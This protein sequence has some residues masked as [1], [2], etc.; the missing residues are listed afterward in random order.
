MK[1]TVLLTVLLIFASFT[2]H[3]LVIR[4]P[5][6]PARVK[7]WHYMLNFADYYIGMTYEHFDRSKLPKLTLANRRGTKFSDLHI[8]EYNI[9]SESEGHKIPVEILVPKNYDKSKPTIFQIHGGGF[10][11][12]GN[13]IYPGYLTE[14]GNLVVSVF[15]RL[16]PEYPFPAQTNDVFEAFKWL[17]KKDHKLLKD[18][19]VSNIIVVGDS[20]GGN[21]AAGLSYR[22][23]DEKFFEKKIKKQVLVY[24]VIHINV[25]STQSRIDHEHAYILPRH[26]M[27]WF[28][29]QYHE[30]QKILA[31]NPLA[32]ITKAKNHKNLP[33]TFLIVMNYDPLYSEG[34]DYGELLKKN[35]VKVEIKEYPTV[36]GAYGMEFIEEGMK[37]IKDTMKFISK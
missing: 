31:E 37:A 30:D 13:A 1:S 21:L 19:D 11:L 17:Y 4:D 22:V 5:E 8:E 23:R 3:T 25:V 16:A 10:V 15:Y 9:T 36:H 18:V 2:Y 32:S 20:A 29:A 33:E 28:S 12:Q 7:L 14:N 24:P 6:I 35:D 34:K 26:K 27:I